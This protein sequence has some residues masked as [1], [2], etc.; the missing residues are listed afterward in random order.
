MVVVV[1]VDVVV[2]EGV[3]AAPRPRALAKVVR[4]FWRR[5]PLALAM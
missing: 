5:T 2:E 3:A 1:E 4:S